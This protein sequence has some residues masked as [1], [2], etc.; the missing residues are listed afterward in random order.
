MNFHPLDQINA[1]EINKAV[2]LLRSYKDLDKDT[3]FV[4]ISLVE[5]EKEFVRNYR[6]GD[7]CPRNLKI[8]GIEQKNAIESAVQTLIT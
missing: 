7:D 6:Q 5:P 1:E 8:R 2:D 3:L 4:N